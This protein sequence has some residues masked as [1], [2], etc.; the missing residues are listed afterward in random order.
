MMSR[1]LSLAAALLCV[2]SRGSCNVGPQDP[3]DTAAK[4][5]AFRLPTT[6]R[7]E[8]YELRFAPDLRDGA[9]STFSGV[10]DITVTALSAV[11]AIT[12][13]LRD[14]DV[15]AATVMD[16]K[17]RRDVPVDRLVYRTGDEQLEIRLGKSVPAGRKYLVTVRYGGKIRTDDTG[18]YTS[19][20]T[21]PGD[22]SA[23]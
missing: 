20:Y 19:S 2:L 4:M 23:K 9:N 14:L 5:T 21:E 10:A 15:T 13:N 17:L 3:Q 16:V 18:L 7:P 11:D 6:T 22:A 8:S 1:L 12:L